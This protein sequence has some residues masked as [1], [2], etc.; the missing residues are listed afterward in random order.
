MDASTP[1]WSG[2][3]AITLAELLTGLDG[4]SVWDLFLDSE[5]APVRQ[6][7]PAVAAKYAEAFARAVDL[8]SVW[9]AAHCTP[10]ACWRQAAGQA[11][12][13]DRATIDQ[14]RIAGWLHDLGRVA[15]PNLVWDKP[16]PLN[17][18]E[19]EQ[20]RLHA[21]HTERLLARSALAGAPGTTR[22]R[23]P[24]AVR[25]LGLPEVAARLGPG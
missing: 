21:Y 13:F 5:P 22:R 19:W 14:L 16:G 20:V 9:T 12:G 10:W 17:A 15:V 11:A 18:A 23:P 24:R 1:A 2:C 7:S 4:G 6:V 8:K 3:S 25:R